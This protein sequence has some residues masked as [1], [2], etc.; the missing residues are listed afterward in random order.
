[1]EGEEG[2]KSRGSS[3]KEFGKLTQCSHHMQYLYQMKIHM[4]LFSKFYMTDSN[5]YRTC[6]CHKFS[7]QQFHY[8][9]CACCP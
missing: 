1:M 5:S 6:T 8:L 7:V 4:A 3:G 9:S 2:A